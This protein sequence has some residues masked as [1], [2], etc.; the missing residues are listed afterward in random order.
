MWRES[1]RACR[2]IVAATLASTA[3]AAC[4]PTAVTDTP[5]R[6]S[7]P[8]GEARRSS[9]HGAGGSAIEQ[10]AL[11]QGTYCDPDPGSA[12]DCSLL[13]PDVGWIFGYCIDVGCPR[14]YVADIGGVNAR[15]WALRQFAPALPPYSVDGTV[16]ESR[17]GDGRRHLIVNLRARNTLFA[18]WD[19]QPAPLFGSDLMEYPTIAPVMAD[20]TSAI[21]LV[22]PANF[23]GMPDLTQLLFDPEPGMEI[24]RLSTTATAEGTLRRA[25]DDIPAGTRVEVQATS[26]Y[27]PRLEARAVPGKRL[28]ALT[29]DPTSRLTVKPVR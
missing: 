26:R 12:I 15:Y 23:V 25:Y 24:R 2:T 3:I 13:P 10:F 5:G 28:V 7:S 4:N 11:A 20:L 22:L 21:E 17:L 19:D 6:A 14:F 18:I 27:L 16:A 1:T 9:D 29:Y 8:I